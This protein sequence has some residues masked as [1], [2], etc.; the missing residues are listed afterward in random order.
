[1]IGYKKEYLQKVKQ[2]FNDVQSNQ[3]EP[4]KPVGKPSNGKT[5]KIRSAK[6]VVV[7]R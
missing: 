6:G 3:S 1:M 2:K 7:P 4:A 5:G